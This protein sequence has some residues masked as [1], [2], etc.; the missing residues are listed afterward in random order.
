MMKAWKKKM[1]RSMGRHYVVLVEKT[2]LLMNSGFAVT[3]V[4]SGFMESVLRSPRLGLS[5][6]SSTSAHLAAT[7][8]HGLDGDRRAGSLY[9]GMM[10]C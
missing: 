8:E 3:S 1:M 2:M 6:L 10:G 4:R 9:Y 5:I 7:R